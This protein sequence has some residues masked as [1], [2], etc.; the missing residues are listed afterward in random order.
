MS[1]SLHFWILEA[2]DVLEKS[3]PNTILTSSEKEAIRIIV[4]NES[5]GNP[6]AINLWD[7]NARNGTPSKGLMQLIDPTFKEFAVP[8]YLDIWNP[9]DNIIA[10]V[11]YASSRYSSL[12]D[13][14]GVQAVR[15]GGRYVG[16]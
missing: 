9:V 10:G 12:D 6:K 2:A 4:E 7:S 16:Y 14:P 11:R 15:K 8:G 13:V 5:S 3:Y 1:D